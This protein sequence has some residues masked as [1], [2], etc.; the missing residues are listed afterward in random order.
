RTVNVVLDP[1]GDE[2]GDGVSN[3]AES[4]AGTNPLVKNILRF[5][6]IDMLALG[7]GN[8]SIAESN[9]GGGAPV[10]FRYGTPA[11]YGGVPFFITDQS[12]QVWHAARAPGG[13]GSGPVS[14][15]FPM[16][17]NNVYGFYTLAGLWWGA[18]GFY[19]TYTFNFSDG[20]SYS[21]ILTNN[22]DLRDYNIPSSWANSINGTTTQNVFAS[23]NYHLDRQWIDFAAAGHGGKNLIS[24]TVTDR[25]AWGSSR[26]FL[27]AA[28][29]QVGAPGQIPPGATDTD[30][31]G[32]LDNYELG[33]PLSTK[34]DD[35]DTD[36]DGLGDGIEVGGVTDPLNPDSD[37]D[38]LK[39]G[40]EV[41]TYGS[42]PNIVDTDGDT[43]L[44]GAEVALGTNP[45]N[46]DTD[47][48]KVPDGVEATN[49]TSP[50]NPASNPLP[51]ITRQ[52]LGGTK[53]Q[54]DGWTFTVN[55]TDPT[56]TFLVYQWKKNGVNLGGGTF[57][58]FLTISSLQLSDAGNYEVIVSNPLG[59]TTS[60]VVT[61]V[62]VDPTT[63]T[64]S[65][66]PGSYT[67]LQGAV[68]LD[69][70]LTVSGGET[71][72]GATIQIETGFASGDT[73]SLTPSIGGI[74]GIYDGSKGIL[75]LS[76][77][78]SASAYQ[79][80]LRAV[81]FSTTSTST[82]ERGFKVTLG[83]AISFGG[84]YYEYVPGSHSWTGA[85]TLALSKTF[86]GLSGYLA[87]LTSADENNFVKTK[88]GTDVWIG[89]SDEGTEGVWKWM[90]GPEAGIT[91]W[92]GLS[93]GSA[94]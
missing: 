66:A 54:G 51:A 62:V 91:F 5:Q 22:V 64:L 30:G 26:I 63:I 20:S 24:F 25:G 2:D 39:D 15:T 3:G 12:N 73:L 52:L 82:A 77:S 7:K 59:S 1:A 76:G 37:N 61:L 36:D 14:V 18:A 44:D 55:A 65:T 9:G 35:A 48:D 46:P 47:G 71:F 90:D 33:L 92:N 21:K 88:I 89:G 42:N 74:T 78:G 69:N 40:E 75:T 56:A 57:D 34:P 38:G 68:P 79:S 60:S 4:L 8:F 19:V 86:N 85:R 11:Y 31:D 50:L 6:T 32:I 16:A 27:A 93:T 49:G 84:H 17:V 70:S 41:I 53:N 10:G 13:D 81:T 43:L 94:P 23:G 29:A 58:N 67:L 87:N 72:S 83:S 80:A 45:T 28:T